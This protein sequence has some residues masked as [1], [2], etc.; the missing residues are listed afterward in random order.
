M[1]QS[2]VT[3]SAHLLTQIALCTRCPGD[4]RGSERVSGLSKATGKQ[5]QSQDLSLRHLL[6]IPILHHCC[7]FGSPLLREPGSFVILWL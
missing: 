5:V 7:L 3:S 2:C 6:K 4:S 1:L